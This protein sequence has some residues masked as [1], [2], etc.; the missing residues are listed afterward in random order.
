MPSVPP[1]SHSVLPLY[2]LITVL[3]K[4]YNDSN[5][6]SE[7]KKV[8]LKALLS[9]TKIYNIFKTRCHR[10]RNQF[11]RGDIWPPDFSVSQAARLIHVCGWVN[12]A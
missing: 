8:I 12:M 7:F 3:E 10:H 9:P 4:Q 5:T 1:D 11:I 2:L 6:D